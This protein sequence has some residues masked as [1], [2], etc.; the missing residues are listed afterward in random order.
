MGEP[1]GHLLSAPWGYRFLSVLIAYPFT[2]LPI[3]NFSKL[4]E[5]SSLVAI[6]ANQALVCLNYRSSR[7]LG[8][9]L[10]NLNSSSLVE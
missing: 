5:F 4:P 2:Y 10:Q 6:E 9:F 7:T 3:V 8:G 1:E